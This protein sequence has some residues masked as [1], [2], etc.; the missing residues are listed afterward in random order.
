[1]SSFRIA[2]LPHTSSCISLV[3]LLL[4]LPHLCVS[5]YNQ[6]FKARLQP[7]LGQNPGLARTPSRT[8]S[9][10]ALCLHRALCFSCGISTHSTLYSVSHAASPV[11]SWKLRAN[12]SPSPA[13]FSLARQH[14]WHRQPPGQNFSPC[15]GGSRAARVQALAVPSVWPYLAEQGTVPRLVQSHP[16]PPSSARRCWPL[17]R[18]LPGTLPILG[19]WGSSVGVA[20]SS[21]EKLWIEKRH[22][23]E[24]RL[25]RSRAIQGFSGMSASLRFKREVIKI[26][27]R[28]SCLQLH[29]KALQ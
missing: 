4:L 17:R 12:W 28:V 18:V 26:Y 1:M 16:Q 6:I 9:L 7:C 15:L 23:E 27:E 20:L 8:V 24:E 25:G 13:P 14:A 22:K 2:T 21:L 19:P 11:L 29:L 3:T 10:P 5:K